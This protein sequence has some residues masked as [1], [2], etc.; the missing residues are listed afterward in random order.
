MKKYSLTVVL[1]LALCPFSASTAC[2][3]ADARAASLKVTHLQSGLLQQRLEFDRKGE[4]APAAL[5]TRIDSLEADLKPLRERFAAALEPQ[6]LTI[7]DD[8]P[9][10]EGFCRDFAQL[11]ARHTADGEQVAE[12]TLSAATPFACEGVDDATLWQRYSDAM[13]A[14]TPLLQSGRI[15]QSQA[16]ALSQKFATFGTQMSTDPAAACAT[17][18]DIERDVAAYSR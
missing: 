8:S 18:K 4:P 12:T 7:Q 14:Q 9:M 10:D 2:S 16:L 11:L 15:D 17:L 1:T 3:Y 13:Q 6:A 5:M